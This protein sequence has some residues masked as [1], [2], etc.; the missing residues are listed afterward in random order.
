MR[1]TG[2]FL[3]VSAGI[4]FLLPVPTRAAT[5]EIPLPGLCGTYST[6]QLTR[7]QS[8]DLGT[9]IGAVQGGWIRWSGTVTPGTAHGDGVCD[10]LNH[11]IPWPAGL[12]ALVDRTEDGTQWTHMDPVSGSFSVVAPFA[13]F[14]LEPAGW[15]TI[16]D[17]RGTVEVE[18]DPGGFICGVGV[19]PPQISVGE[20]TLILDVALAVPARPTTWGQ[21]KARYASP[22]PAGAMKPAQ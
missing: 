18:M 2:A 9:R 3:L 1:R 19:V 14:M 11:W 10:D 7:E 4:F 16:L 20:A 17:G 15:P 8:F 5:I 22:G 13:P 12:I 21:L 6:T